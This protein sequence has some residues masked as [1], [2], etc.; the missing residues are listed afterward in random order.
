ML[1]RGTEINA[2][3]SVAAL[4]YSGVFDLTST[5]F[6]IAGIAGVNPARATSGSVTF[7]RFEVQVALQYEFDIRDID[8]N[9]STGYIPYGTHEPESYP[10]HI[11]GTEVFEVNDALRQKAIAFAKTAKLND[12][13]AAETYRKRFP[14]A[15]ANQP[16][17]I[18]A[19][20]GATSDVFYHGPTLGNA[21]DK[22]TSVITNGTGHYCATAQEDSAMLE[23]FL[24]GAKAGL[25]D[26][27]RIIVMRTAANFDRPPP[28]L[29]PYIEFFY[30]SSGGFGPSV[31]NL[32]LAGKPIVDGIVKGWNSE[33]KAGI[34]PSNYIGDIF[35]TLGGVPDFGPYPNFGEG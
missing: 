3:S 32:A 5:Y 16:P 11:Y 24:R 23:V 28:D 22:Y 27:G 19:C 10:A 35:G 26:F 21:F 8:N 29:S 33:Y 13:K 6:L 9:F 14:H 17:S 20:D 2:A 25:V 30:R 18:V 7:A 31:A 12:T 4:L 34:K 15:P 1:M